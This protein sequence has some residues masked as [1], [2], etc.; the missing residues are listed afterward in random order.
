MESQEVLTMRAMAWERAKGELN[1]VLATYWPSVGSDGD[2]ARMEMIERVRN[3][4]SSP[5][6]KKPLTC[7]SSTAS[8]GC[9]SVGYG[10]CGQQFVF[11]VQD[12]QVVASSQ[13]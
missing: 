12:R 5:R 6:L 9:C 2:T 4:T 11:V 13:R 1:A 10:L 3:G 8:Y 7:S